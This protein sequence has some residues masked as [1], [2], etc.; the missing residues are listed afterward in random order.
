M[1][2]TAPSSTRQE[3]QYG[4]EENVGAPG[5]PNVLHQR[6]QRLRLARRCSRRTNAPLQQGPVED[7]EWNCDPVQNDRERKETVKKK[8]IEGAS[9]S[10]KLL[11]KKWKSIIV[12]KCDKHTI[13]LLGILS[14]VIFYI[15]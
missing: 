12:K 2:Q 4:P 5:W 13:F 15:S 10:T 11:M 8:R 1:L 9:I 14:F 7:E 3:L 6:L